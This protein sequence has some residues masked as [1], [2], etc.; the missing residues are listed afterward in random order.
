MHKWGSATAPDDLETLTAYLAATYGRSA[1]AYTSRTLPANE[2][3]AA[4]ETLPDGRYARGDRQRGV[5]LYGDRCE[6][7]HEKA[8]QGGPEGITLSGRHILERASEFAAI[9]RT[10]RGR[11]PGAEDATDG[12]IAD[13]LAY[14][15]AP[16]G[17]ASP[18]P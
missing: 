13:I 18:R 15:R 14:L 2:A 1:G 17:S 16:A 4:F 8:G 11:M 12:E 3:A 7:C 10:G 6:P 5:T 9:V